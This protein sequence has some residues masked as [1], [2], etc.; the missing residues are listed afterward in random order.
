MW[1]GLIGWNTWSINTALAFRSS[2]MLPH[3]QSMPHHW[4][5]EML[6][7]HQSIPH[8]RSMSHHHTVYVNIVVLV[9]NTVYVNNMICL[10][11]IEYPFILL[12]R[13]FTVLS[14]I[15]HFVS[16]SGLSLVVKWPKYF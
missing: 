8:H 10:N 14:S 5:N 13:F 16:L 15:M 11:N 1:K 7:L 12:L 6:L 3:H 2:K 9:N 4:S